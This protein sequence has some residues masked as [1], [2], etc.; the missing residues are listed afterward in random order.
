[1]S[2]L[3][4]RV[5]IWFA[6]VI[7]MFSLFCP[8]WGIFGQF[9]ATSLFPD[10]EHFIRAGGSVETWKLDWYRNMPMLLAAFGGVIGIFVGIGIFQAWR[11]LVDTRMPS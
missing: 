8:L 5:I 10:A 11:L 7:G 6:F 4:H 1:M 3:T 9:M 2:N